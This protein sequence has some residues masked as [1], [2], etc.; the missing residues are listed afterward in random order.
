MIRWI[1]WIRNTPNH[2]WAEI[3]STSAP[4]IINCRRG[5]P[6]FRIWY[7]CLGLCKQK[8]VTRQYPTICFENQQNASRM[9][10]GLP[11][12]FQSRSASCGIPFSGLRKVRF[13]RI[14]SFV[15]VVNGSDSVCPDSS[16]GG[17]SLEL[18]APGSGDCAS[19]SLLLID[20]QWNTGRFTTQPGTAKS[21]VLNTKDYWKAFGPADNY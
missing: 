21:I 12:L 10:W 2:W 6:M 8:F 9:V 19:S 13:L 11:L 1:M 5:D 17:G 3:M 16:G 18:L 14:D 15:G 4:G 7:S 20:L